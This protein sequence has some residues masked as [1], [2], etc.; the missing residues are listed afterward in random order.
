MAD[1]KPIR[2]AVPRGAE[3]YMGLAQYFLTHE[4]NM[5][6]SFSQPSRR[7]RRTLPDGTCI[8]YIM[9]DV[10]DCI[11]ISIPRKLIEGAG[12]EMVWNKEPPYSV[13]GNDQPI[14]DDEGKRTWVIDLLSEEMME[15]ENVEGGYYFIVTVIN[16]TDASSKALPATFFIK[17]GEDGSGGGYAG[18][19]IKQG[20]RQDDGSYNVDGRSATI[21]LGDDVEGDA[22]IVAN[23]LIT[24][25]TRKIALDGWQILYVPNPNHSSGRYIIA[26]KSTLEPSKKMLNTVEA[27]HWPTM[28]GMADLFYAAT[29]SALQ[30]S[31]AI[32]EGDIYEYSGYNV[33][34]YTATETSSQ[35]YTY[36]WEVKSSSA[37]DATVYWEDT[38]TKT[39]SWTKQAIF[40][41]SWVIGQPEPAGPTTWDGTT[42]VEYFNAW[43]EI[44]SSVNETNLITYEAYNL[45]DYSWAEDA[46]HNGFFI[47]KVE[48][49]SNGT[50]SAITDCFVYN[51]QVIPL[52][53][54][55]YTPGVGYVGNFVEG[56]KTTCY[57]AEDLLSG[58]NHE[59][60]DVLVVSY[61]IADGWS[62]ATEKI[63]NQIQTGYLVVIRG[64]III[65][66]FSSTTAGVHELIEKE[67]V[68]LYSKGWFYVHKT[69]GE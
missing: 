68:Q 29:A 57:K 21:L 40:R 64:D 11:M 19:S 8:D 38:T 49:G 13:D 30:A 25:L 22:V 17:A 39:Y 52:V 65:K 16:G 36:E 69:S 5:C 4:E 60:E 56:I 33:R 58:G 41:K 61:R 26:N 34:D 37:L 55:T 63:V 43:H 45:R 62:N 35:V 46:T 66:T 20:S 9:N 48:I 47:R 24:T 14:V 1:S 2:W 15:D 42:G 18:W 54:G 53:T 32:D 27:Q 28:G 50:S 3:G 59:P 10:V 7:A 12:I 6:Q 51:R 31:T 44:S 67:G 23:D